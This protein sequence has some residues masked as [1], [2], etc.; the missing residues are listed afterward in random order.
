MKA[1]LLLVASLAVTVISAAPA[2]ADWR[3]TSPSS[4]ERCNGGNWPTFSPTCRNLG[5]FKT[6]A[7]C[8]EGGAKIGWRSSDN[9]WFCS[10]L[11]F[12]N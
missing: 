1:S 9:W 11:G 12:K 4:P 6:Y 10:S 3:Q 7:E 2:N 8:L 5:K